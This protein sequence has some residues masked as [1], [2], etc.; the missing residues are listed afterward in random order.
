MTGIFCP[1]VHLIDNGTIKSNDGILVR[2]WYSECQS[3]IVNFQSFLHIATVTQSSF[4]ELQI[5]VVCGL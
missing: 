4:L 2:P 3:L 5:A 1:I